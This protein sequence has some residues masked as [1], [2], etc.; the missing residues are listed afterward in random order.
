LSA[1]INPFFLKLLLI[2]V[3]YHSNRNPNYNGRHDV[4]SEIW[5]QRDC[6]GLDG[7]DPHR[8]M[9]IIRRHD[10]VEGS[11]SLRGRGTTWF[12]SSSQAQAL[13]LSAA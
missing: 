4:I 13:P 7:N 2:I 1:E 3:F 11:V 12:R 10:L 9:D 6:G 5:S 8:P